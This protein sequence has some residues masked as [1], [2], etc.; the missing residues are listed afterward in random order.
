MLNVVTRG[1]R[2]RSIS[3]AYNYS[4]NCILYLEFHVSP[5]SCNTK[6]A[7]DGD[8]WGLLD[9]RFVLRVSIKLMS[10]FVKPLCF[11]GEIDETLFFVRNNPNTSQ[12]SIL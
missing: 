4:V 10:F 8:D 12:I 6:L 9:I 3:A 5:N 7:N 11:L 1:G 2:K